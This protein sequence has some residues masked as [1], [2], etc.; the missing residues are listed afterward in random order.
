MRTGAASVHNGGDMPSLELP[1]QVVVRQHLPTH[2]LDDPGAT[3]VQA[4]RRV[5]GEPWQGRRVAVALGSRGIDRI[6]LVARTLIGWL[7]ERGADSFVIPAMGSHGGATPE[8]QCELLASYGITSAA[9]GVPIRAEME[10]DEIGL[11]A[12]GISVRLA[13]VAREADAIVLVNR[14]KPHTDF[15]SLTLG[16]GL[17]KMA[18]IGLGKIDGASRCH[19]AATRLGYEIALG[20]VGRAVLSSGSRVYG[21]ALLEDAGHHLA[22]IEVLRGDEIPVEEPMLLQQ[23]RTW[24]PALPFA[25]VDVLVVDAIG[26]NVS[27]AGMDPN[28]IG[29]G[30]HG[31]RMAMCRSCVRAIYARDLTPESH[32]NAVGVGL[33]D[34]VSTRIVEAMDPVITYTNAL[35]AMTIAPVRIPFH[36]TTDEECLAAAFRLA[37]VPP[38][39]ARLLRIR[40]TLSLERI[41]ASEAYLPEIG[42]RDD[43]EAFLPPR[44]WTFEAWD[45]AAPAA[46]PA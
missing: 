16:S 13:R 17:I 3:L 29:R 41:I 15:E 28:V 26:K 19:E 11:T 31:E 40:D 21:V 34:V 5:A 37:G 36:F 27:G 18:A 43:L 2:A 14:V 12:S 32:G 7:R 9:L 38:A 33:A 1:R 10:T 45:G 30:V 22:R 8:G 23:A 20:E 25:D 4:L 42:A 24:M 39:Q 44:P 6:A 46:Q 35:A